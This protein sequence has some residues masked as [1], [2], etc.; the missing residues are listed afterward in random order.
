M[1]SPRS[2]AS[3]PA[4]RF[5]P[6][7]GVGVAVGDGVSV[8]VASGLEVAVGRGGLVAVVGGLVPAFRSALQLE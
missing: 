1:R 2:L 4:F 3:V 7:A 5:G 6:G 8:A